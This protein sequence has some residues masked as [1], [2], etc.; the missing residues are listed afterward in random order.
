MKNNKNNS[1]TVR[2]MSQ[3]AYNLY[4]NKELDYIANNQATVS[5]TS[6]LENII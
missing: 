5:D 1:Y 4:R 2:R 6:K 3:D